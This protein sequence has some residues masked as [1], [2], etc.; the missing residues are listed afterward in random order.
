[1]TALPKQQGNTGDCVLRQTQQSANKESTNLAKKTRRPDAFTNTVKD[2]SEETGV[3]IST[4]LQCWKTRMY[5]LNNPS[6]LL[7]LVAPLLL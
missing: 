6:L 2:T 1:L 7:L 4:L 3:L 5:T